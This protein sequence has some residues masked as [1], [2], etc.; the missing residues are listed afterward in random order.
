MSDNVAIAIVTG[1]VSVLTSLTAAYFAFRA[2]VVAK[3]TH[4]VVNSRMDEFKRMAEKMFTAE[5]VLKEKAAEQERKAAIET[6]KEQ[7]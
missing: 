7:P 2:K 3:E 5:G 1:I 6:T 4:L